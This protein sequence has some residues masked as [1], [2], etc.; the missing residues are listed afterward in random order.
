MK[1][2]TVPLALAS[3]I[4]FVSCASG[5]GRQPSPSSSPTLI[6]HVTTVAGAPAANASVQLSLLTSYTDSDGNFSFQLQSP[7]IYNLS[8]QGADGVFFAQDVFVSNGDNQLTVVLD[9]SPSKFTVV[10][11]NPHLNS[12]EALLLGPIE[13]TFSRSIN[14]ASISASSF[15]LTPG[16]G[17]IEFVVD[18]ASVRLYPSR[19]LKPGQRYRLRIAGV[20]AVDGTRLSAE[21]FTFFCTTAIDKAAPVAL[22]S[23]PSNGASD[24]PLNQ[25]VQVTYSDTIAPPEGGYSAAIEPALE[26]RELAAEDN[27]LRIILA[28]MFIPNTDYVITVN[29]VQDYSGNLSQPFQVTFRTGTTAVAFDDIEPA[30]NVFANTIIFSRAIGGRYDLYRINADGSGLSQVTD[31][32]A[33]ERHPSFSSDG[34]LVAYAS[35]VSGN[36]DV[37]VRSL[38]SGASS[39]LTFLPENETSPA[40]CG[41]Y[42]QIIAFVRSEGLPSNSRIYLMNADGSFSRRAD[43]RSSRDEWS[44]IFHPLL[45]N[46]LLYV[47]NEGGDND[48]FSKS[49]FIDSSNPVNVNLTATLTG[50]ESAASFSADGSTIAFLSDQTGV[51][52]VWVMDPAGSAHYAVTRFSEPVHS[53]AYSPIA[54]D[55]RVVVSMGPSSSRSLYVVSLVSG[56]IER[57]LTE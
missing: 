13:I 38:T 54:G 47:T 51:R 30:W 45:D 31:T 3:L 1:A 4:F 28:G 40:F 36:W 32:S 9:P 15:L 21:A 7:G 56:N 24:V 23:I 43:E 50:N 44:P 5:H 10:R 8:I 2:S 14:P 18:G 6:G 49:A 22:A 42:S 26:I 48:I 41:T 52:N 29:P 33:N 20:S 25:A 53:L 19:E 17:E 12:Q 34:S 35:D 57:R 55:D 16:V 11:V 39:Q 27:I 37:W 46:Q